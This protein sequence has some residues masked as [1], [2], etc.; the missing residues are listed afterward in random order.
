[1]KNTYIIIFGFLS[2]VSCQSEKKDEVSEEVQNSS[3]R[4]VEFTSR[5]Y[6]AAG[7]RL[8]RIERKNLK[9]VIQASG[10]LEVPP[11]N[12]ANVAAVMGGVI[13]DIYVLE[14]NHVKKGQAL[15]KMEHPDI[16][17]LQEDYIMAIASL[18]YLEKEFQRQKELHEQNVGTGKVFE[19]TSSDYFA[20]KGKVSALESQLRM[21]HLPV[22]Q[23]ATGKISPSVTLRAPI[24]GYVGHIKAKIGDY[25]APDK[26]LFDIVDNSK[27]HVDLLVYE[28]DL[29]KVKEGQTIQFILTN[30]DNQ[31]ISGRIF[32]ISKSFENE[33]KALV[34]H[35]EIENKGHKNLIAGMYVNA[36]VDIGDSTV[37]A[38]PEEAVAHTGGGEFIFVVEGNDDPG[39]GSVVFKKVEIKTGVE[40][41]GYVEI[42][43]T[44]EML[45]DARIVVKGAF[46]V[47]SQM[48][49]GGEE[50]E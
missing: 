25:A 11:Q 38:L 31:Q 29:F 49:A 26:P 36:L 3:N 37:S 48:E 1:M 10:Y 30:Q 21:L 7:I 43:P 9:D 46:Y 22:D 5:Q 13:T 15:A 12:E 40:N 2:L 4:V 20:A 35:A 28:K 42:R 34:V 27:L 32:G 8:G 47:L 24:T 18:Q 6:E 16:V 14:G 39:N 33:T 23:I 41:L 45:P 17:K 44:E 50:E 19:Q